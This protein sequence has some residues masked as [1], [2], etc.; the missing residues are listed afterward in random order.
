[1]LYTINFLL[2]E[3]ELLENEGTSSYFLKLKRNDSN[4]NL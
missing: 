3:E 4:E 1:M 2:E